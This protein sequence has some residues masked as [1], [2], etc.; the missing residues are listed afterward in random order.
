MLFFSGSRYFLLEPLSVV[1]VISCRE[2][3]FSENIAFYENIASSGSCSAFSL[4]YSFY[5]KLFFLVEVIHFSGS[6][7]F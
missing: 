4:N 3:H 5:W 6:H 2:M 7:S 1:K